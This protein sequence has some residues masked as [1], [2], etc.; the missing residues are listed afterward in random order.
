[1]AFLL[2]S[3]RN[4]ILQIHFLIG[5]LQKLTTSLIFSFLHLGRS[6]QN[7]QHKCFLIAQG[8][9]CKAE[10]YDRETMKAST[11]TYK[12]CL[13]YVFNMAKHKLVEDILKGPTHKWSQWMHC[14]QRHIPVALNFRFTLKPFSESEGPVCLLRALYIRINQSVQVER[15][16]L[17]SFYVIGAGNII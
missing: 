16:L 12:Q 4:N 14:M 3:R 7:W 6:L 2:F 8:S 5:C 1:M 11:P 13:Q 9:F 10:R 17:S 15:C